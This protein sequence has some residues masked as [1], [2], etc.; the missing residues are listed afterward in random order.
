MMGDK[1]FIVNENITLKLEKSRTNI[2]VSGEKFI[3][4]KFLLLEIPVKEAVELDE[5]KSID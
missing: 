5:L 1:E 2:Y 4:C 3:Q